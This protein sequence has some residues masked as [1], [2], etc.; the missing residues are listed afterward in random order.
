MRKQFAEFFFLATFLIH[1]QVFA[2]TYSIDK[3]DTLPTNAWW[4]ATV[5]GAQ[6][7]ISDPTLAQVMIENGE[8]VVRTVRPGDLMVHVHLPDGRIHRVLLHIYGNPI[9]GSAVSANYREEALWYVNEYRAQNG[10][11]PLSLDYELCG[12]ADTRAR[13]IMDVYAHE[14]PD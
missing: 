4:K 12:Y 10:L 9:D 5:A 1:F 6:Y 7:G 11:P 3:E 2:E 14:R 8:H 13:E